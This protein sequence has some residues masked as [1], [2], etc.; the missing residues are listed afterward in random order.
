MLNG[1]YIIYS[2]LRYFTC[3]WCHKSPRIT[4][5]D[6]RGHTEASARKCALRSRFVISISL[7]SLACV[8]LAKN[9]CVRACRNPEE[10][11]ICIQQALH[12]PLPCIITR[13]LRSTYLRLSIYL[14]SIRICVRA[15][16]VN[17]CGSVHLC[18]YIY[19]GDVYILLL[20]YVIVAV[21]LLVILLLLLF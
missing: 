9:A 5:F 20:L 11:P 2:R 1:V 15:R 8:R 3:L 18:S 17:V 14:F 16:Y 12:V 21:L 4:L 13:C 6:R 19:D 10:E 7:V